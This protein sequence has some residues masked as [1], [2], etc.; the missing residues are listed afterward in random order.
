M[1]GPALAPLALALTLGTTFLVARS[2]RGAQRLQFV[3]ALAAIGVLALVGVLA[4]STPIVRMT[5]DE[6]HAAFRKDAELY[7]SLDRGIEASLA[8]LETAGVPPAEGV[9]NADQ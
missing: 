6:L 8:H 9:L 3:L 1:A 7:D 5:R 2:V 4:E